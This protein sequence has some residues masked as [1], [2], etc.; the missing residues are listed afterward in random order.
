MKMSGQRKLWPDQVLNLVSLVQPLILLFVVLLMTAMVVSPS[1]VRAWATGDPTSAPQPPL[2]PPKDVPPPATPVTGSQTGTTEKPLT[3]KEFEDALKSLTSE[4]AKQTKS[5]A[6]DAAKKTVEDQAASVLKELKEVET[7]IGNL[8]G[9]LPKQQ[10]DKDGNPVPA[11]SA[12]LAMT[13]EQF[14]LAL[15]AE[16]GPFAKQFKDLRDSIEGKLKILEKLPKSDDLNMRLEKLTEKEVANKIAG[17]MGRLAEFVK[18]AKEGDRSPFEKSL[19][20]NLEFKLDEK[21]TDR[22]KR[23]AEQLNEII[24]GLHTLENSQRQANSPERVAVIAC[25][26]RKLAWSV[27]QPIMEPLKS[28]PFHVNNLDYQWGIYTAG[29]KAINNKSPVMPL[30]EHKKE[31]DWGSPPDSQS[32][33]FG[34]MQPQSLFG[35]VSPQQKDKVLHRCLLLLEADESP[36]ELNNPAWKTLTVDAIVLQTDARATDEEMGKAWSKWDVFCTA[37]RGEAVLLR[38]KQVADGNRTSRSFMADESAKAVQL[39]LL[40][41]LQPRVSPVVGHE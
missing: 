26:S 25:N 19:F 37:H 16:S 6:E 27:Y 5:V 15:S 38:I 13:E 20:D 24:K 34:E 17:E 8:I 3:K 33:S 4:L 28:L 18:P 23:H 39:R 21:F 40:R 32:I 10:F 36:P 35:E 7:R 12:G 41:L 22:L 31:W 11:G 30:G 14:K 2:I 29:T 1:A 9:K